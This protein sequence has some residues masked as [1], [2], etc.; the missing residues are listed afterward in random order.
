M[1]RINNQQPVGLN[2][3]TLGGR[4]LKHICRASELYFA[5]GIAPNQHFVRR[6]YVFSGEVDGKYITFTSEQQ[7]VPSDALIAPDGDEPVLLKPPFTSYAL[8]WVGDLILSE[9]R[10]PNDR[11][12]RLMSGVMSQLEHARVFQHQYQLA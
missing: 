2:D 6:L 1:R 10:P 3:L 7:V 9:L 5:K 11:E 12:R 4:I 8:F